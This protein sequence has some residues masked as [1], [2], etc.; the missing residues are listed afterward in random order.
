[1]KPVLFYVIRRNVYGDINIMTVTS[2]KHNRL[3]GRDN[4]DTPTNCAARDLIARFPNNEKA[5]SVIKQICELEQDRRQSNKDA[6]RLYDHALVSSKAI[7]DEAL[8]EL[9]K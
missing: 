4:H 1:M 8:K 7:F 6:A 2:E 9:L 5:Q 3:Y